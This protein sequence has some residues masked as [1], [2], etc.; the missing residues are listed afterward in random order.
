M[1]PLW[2][3]TKSGRSLVR[4]MTTI[5]RSLHRI[6][7]LCTCCQKVRLHKITPILSLMSS[8]L[9]LWR[10]VLSPDSCTTMNLSA[11]LLEII[12]QTFPSSMDSI[13]KTATL[14]SDGSTQRFSAQ[15]LMVPQQALRPLMELNLSSGRR[16]ISILLAIAVNT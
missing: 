16:K 4:S 9:K 7:I 5:P 3:S 8:I 11:H 14:I 10:K 6:I 15:K 2:Y 12:Q 13:Q 1:A